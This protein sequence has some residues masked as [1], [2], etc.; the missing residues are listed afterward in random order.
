MLIFPACLF[1]TKLTVHESK[2]TNL[3]SLESLWS[4]STTKENFVVALR[5]MFISCFREPWRSWK[6]HGGDILHVPPSDALVSR[7]S[8]VQDIFKDANQSASV[9]CLRGMNLG[10]LASCP[11]LL[12]CQAWHS[13]SFPSLGEDHPWAWLPVHPA[14]RQQQEQYQSSKGENQDSTRLEGRCRRQNLKLHPDVRW[15]NELKQ[16]KDLESSFQ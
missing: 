7:S 9:Q 6:A 12:L 5:G 8:I 4:Y 3:W 1:Y 15:E 13:F 16:N 11:C 10:P 2:I 14:G